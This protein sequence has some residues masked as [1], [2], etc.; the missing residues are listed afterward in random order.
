MDIVLKE[1]AGE[2]F[3]RY[4]GRPAVN[5]VRACLHLIPDKPIQKF[6]QVVHAYTV[7]GELIQREISLDQPQDYTLNCEDEPQN[8]FIRIRNPSRKNP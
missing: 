5:T 7:D 3:V 1:P 4:T 2:V 6:I 8:E